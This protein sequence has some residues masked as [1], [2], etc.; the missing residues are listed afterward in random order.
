MDSLNK[1][2]NDLASKK[3]ADLQPDVE[4]ESSK[5]E[6]KPLKRNLKQVLEDDDDFE[7]TD[8]RD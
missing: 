4:T 1:T 6:E 8:F 5:D 7:V 3:E 2:F